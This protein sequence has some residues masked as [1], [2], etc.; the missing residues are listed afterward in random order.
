MELKSKN[1]FMIF[2]TIIF[3]SVALIYVRM[4]LMHDYIQFHSYEEIPTYKDM[5][6]NLFY[7][8][9]KLFNK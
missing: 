5:Y 1:F 8:V 4:Y 3:A 6:K 7:S 2:F 9:F